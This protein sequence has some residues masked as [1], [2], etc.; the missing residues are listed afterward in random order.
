MQWSIP[1]LE[2]DS[3]AANASIYARFPILRLEKGTLHKQ[4]YVRTQHSYAVPVSMLRQYNYRVHQAYA[5][6]LSEESCILLTSRLGL[7]T[8]K[9]TPTCIV[10]TTAALRLKVLASTGGMVEN[11]STSSHALQSLGTE[12]YRKHR[13]WNKD[14]NSKENS[15]QSGQQKH[16]G[17][18]DLNNLFSFGLSFWKT[19]GVFLLVGFPI[20]WIEGSDLLFYMIAGLVSWGLLGRNAV[21]HLAISPLHWWILGSLDGLSSLVVFPQRGWWMLV[22]IVVHLCLA[23]LLCL[24]LPVQLFRLLVG[25]RTSKLR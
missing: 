20:W 25:N 5:N 22:K 3:E 14:Y 4:S 18:Y 9:Y 2:T 16:T 10:G 11:A 15:F 8:Q 23:A 1:I 7:D 24:Y 17:N 19:F 21:V 6:R 13:N 12:S